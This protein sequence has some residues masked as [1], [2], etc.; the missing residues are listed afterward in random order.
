MS[1]NKKPALGRGLS[2]LLENAYSPDLTNSPAIENGWIKN[3][4]IDQIETN[5]F[6]PR[7]QFDEEALAELAAS[8]KAMGI[9]QPITVRKLNENK[10]QLISGERRYRAS[11]IAGLTEIPAYVRVANDEN[12]LEMA[13]VE[14]IQRENLDA[15]EI[16]ISLKRLMEECSLT[17]EELSEKIGKKRSTIANFLRLLK[18]P[19]EIQMAIRRRAISMGHARALINIESE[20]DQLEICE[21]IISEGWSV[22]QVEDWVKNLRNKKNKTLSKEKTPNP[23]SFIQ[24]KIL[25][26][27]QQY[28]EKPIEIKTSGKKGKGKLI[29][30][31]ESESELEQLLEKITH[32]RL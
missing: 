21:K 9:I 15:I 6:Q 32:H 11:K 12:M 4:P 13:L 31:F 19:P 24:K 7:N 18:L 20:E 27:L 26:E 29:I 8:I 23:L 1:N 22:R 14:N 17:Q 25:N 16:A 30:S 10:Y 3:I 28:L 2:A 5:P